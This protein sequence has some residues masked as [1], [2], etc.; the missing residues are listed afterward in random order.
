MNDVE[1]S[2]IINPTSYLNPGGRRNFENNKSIEREVWEERDMNH[3]PHIL[4][5]LSIL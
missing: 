4:P 3:H 2:R 1:I 5:S